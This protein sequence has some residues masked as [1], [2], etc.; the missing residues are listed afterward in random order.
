MAQT[1]EVNRFEDDSGKVNFL[2]ILLIAPVPRFP[3]FQDLLDGADEPVRIFQHDSI[4]IVSLRFAQLP[5][6]QRFQVQADRSDGGLEFVRD[7]VQKAILLFVLVDFTNQKDRIHNEASDDQ[8]KKNGAQDEGN[9]L[10]PVEYNPR[11]I[12]RH[13][14]SN[15]EGAQR[16]EKRDLLGTTGN[17]H[18]KAVQTIL[19]AGRTKKK[20]RGV[21][22]RGQLFSRKPCL[23]LIWT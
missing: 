12:Q 15:Q 1:R 21:L 23:D 22:P 8:F 13:R 18:H 17:A 3:C 5:A 4:E 14:Q 19:D 9:N 16:H 7:R 20:P 6:L 10:S 2:P 11:D